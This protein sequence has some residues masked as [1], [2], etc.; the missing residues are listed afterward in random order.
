MFVDY[1]TDVIR[2][3]SQITLK[4]GLN[5]LKLKQSYFL[6]IIAG[7]TLHRGAP[8]FLSVEPTT[9][10]NLNCPQCFRTQPSFTR[11]L[12]NMSV[13]NIKQ[14]LKAFSEHAFY[15]NL[16]FQGEPFMNA[17]LTEF[18][19]MAKRFGFYVA[20][21]TN[22]HFLDDNIA[23]KLVESGLDRLIISLDGTDAAT[24]NEYRKNGDFGIVVNGIQTLVAVKKKVKKKYP[25][26]ELQFVLTRKNQHQRQKIR[27]FGKKLSV[28]RTVVKSMQL[29]NFNEAGDWL[30]DR[31]SRYKKD[32]HGSIILNSRLPNRCFRLWSS[33]VV[34]W[35]G[36]VIP[37]CFD[38]NAAY[39][40][41]NIYTQVLQEI[42]HNEAYDVFRRNVFSKRKNIDICCNCSEGLKK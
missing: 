22:G 23:H 31:S 8:A 12:G 6:S 24:Y 17:G 5:F 32:E 2:L 4:K 38:K 25:F 19:S 1:V 14:I 20:V 15:L 21:S 3:A 37:C 28:S 18:I 35:D 10:C 40:M 27:K 16:Y 41:G 11:P 42:W 30:P 39:S 34:T 7:K 26:I 29:N 9:S 36:N 13:N 33:C